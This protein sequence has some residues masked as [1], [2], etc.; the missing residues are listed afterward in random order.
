MIS[1][2]EVDSCRHLKRNNNWIAKGT[3]YCVKG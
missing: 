3:V 2:P 1:Q